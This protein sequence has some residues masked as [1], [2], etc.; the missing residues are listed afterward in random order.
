[1]VSPFGN[2][3]VTMKLTGAQIRELLKQSATEEKGIL[4]MSGLK[5][6]FNSSLPEDRRLLN[7]IVNGREIDPEEEF[8]VAAQIEGRIID[9]MKD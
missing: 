6:Y 7:V 5:M 1:M 3:I 2:T 4:Q 8:L 9:I